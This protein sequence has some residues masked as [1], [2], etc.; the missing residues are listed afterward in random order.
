M[1]TSKHQLM[2]RS[3]TYL[4]LNTTRL[5]ILGYVLYQEFESTSGDTNMQ[6]QVEDIN[7]L[8]P[9]CS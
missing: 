6:K 7:S 2:F 8:Q 4:Q 1:S 3:T 5:S 9:T